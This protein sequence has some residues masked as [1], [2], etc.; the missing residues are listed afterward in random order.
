MQAEYGLVGYPLTH[1]FS[2]AY[3]NSKFQQEGI[4]A[5]YHSFPIPDISHLPQLLQTHPQLHGLNVT[6][7]Y[8]QSVIS[9]VKELDAVA[10]TIGA[11][12]CIAIHNGSTKGYNTDVIGFEQSLLPLL[13][14]Q[15]THALV[16]GT[17]GA[18]KAVTYVLDKLGINYQMVSRTEGAG[19]MSYNDL[20]DA[21][22]ATHTLII[23]TTPLG[24]NPDIDVMPA[25]QFRSIGTGH[26]LYDLI[27]NPEETLF[28]K[29][30]R[31]QGAQ[32]KNGLEMLH[33]QAEAAWQ[34]WN[35][36]T[37]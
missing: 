10:E 6:I 8:K 36:P 16:L 28:L 3:F 26:L 23:N 22:I 12:N 27:Y 7:P 15:H 14:P 4:D 24:M 31:L 37:V 33:L 34:I 25:I 1:S 21:L 19:C 20:S 2:P 18:S 30:G 29:T 35:Q 11:I 32:T 13:Q 5:V 9:Y 17:G